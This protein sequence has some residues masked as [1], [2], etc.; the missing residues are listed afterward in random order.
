[1]PGSCW[2]LDSDTAA[3]FFG[4]STLLRS[5]TPSWSSWFRGCRARSLCLKRGLK[6]VQASNP[7]TGRFWCMFST[8]LSIPTCRSG[9]SW[10][11]RCLYARRYLECICTATLAGQRTV[12]GDREPKRGICELGLKPSD[13]S[14][15]CPHPKTRMV[16]K[17]EWIEMAQLAVSSILFKIAFR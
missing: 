4:R 2:A 9:S 14:F 10:A 7:R 8:R 5:F 16:K 17:L 12:G 13:S 6:P 1:M 3:P 15:A 11:A